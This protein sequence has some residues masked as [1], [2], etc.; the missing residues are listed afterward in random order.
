MTVN[1]VPVVAIPP[2]VLTV[3]FPVVALAGTVAVTFVAESLVTVAA[4]P[5]N[6]TVAPTRWVPMIV[7]IA[8]TLPE[9][10]LKELIVG[11]GITVKLAG[12][13]A[14]PPAV[15]TVTAPVVAPAGT[16]V[17]IRV[18]VSVAI[19]AATPWNLTAVAAPRFTPVIVTAAPT[20]PFAGFTLE[21]HG[22]PFA[23]MQYVTERASTSE[24]VETFA[25]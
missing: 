20:A 21:M 16:W 14:T 2:A 25:V 15:L 24:V 19:A 10:G 17:V 11:V 6:A 8:P 3:I 12:L 9:C 7:T 13:V 1:A 5:W 18:A 23:T 4:T 22:T